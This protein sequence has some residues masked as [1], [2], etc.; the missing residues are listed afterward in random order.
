MSLCLRRSWAIATLLAAAC[1]PD[2][3]APSVPPVPACAIAPAPVPDIGLRVAFTPW[4]PTRAIV[5]PAFGPALSD[6]MSHE[7]AGV[8]YW[9]DDRTTLA[10]ETTHAINNAIRNAFNGGPL[11]NG[12]YVMNG[13]GVVVAEPHVRKSQVAALVPPSLRS[14]RY[15]T[16][17][18]ERSDWEERSL[19]IWDEWDAYTNGATVA[20]DRYT[21]GL[22]QF[23]PG[24]LIDIVFGVLELTAFGLTTGMAAML[25]DPVDFATDA[26]LRAF[27][28]WQTQRAMAVFRAG[29][30]LPT[31]RWRDADPFYAALRSSPDA[32]P[33]RQFVRATYGGAWTYAVLG[34]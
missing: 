15:P 20:I 16:Y 10:H 8:N 34:F 9:Y 25:Y 3:S 31:Y 26:Q 12:F 18:L 1:A 7:P 30:V 2:P 29:I 14:G 4:P 5:D 11:A 24:Q 23:P 6:V 13:W 19:Y 27:M 22:D 21:R 17:L 33:L 32:E 28:A